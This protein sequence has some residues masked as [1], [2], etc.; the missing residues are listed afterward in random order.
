[1]IAC[2]IP[3]LSVVNIKAMA[4]A[5]CS[6]SFWT[7]SLFCKMNWDIC[8]GFLQI[9]ENCNCESFSC[10]W[11]PPMS[12]SILSLHGLFASWEVGETWRLCQFRSTNHLFNHKS[13]IFYIFKTNVVEISITK[14][15]KEYF[16]SLFIEILLEFI[17]AVYV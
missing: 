16:L 10:L 2:G 7:L 11:Q 1:M 6:V 5:N 17:R 9:L 3:E 14:L 12:K 8:T 13:S 15:S 4:L